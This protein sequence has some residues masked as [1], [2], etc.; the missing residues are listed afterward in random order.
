M[1]G[2]VDT[3]LLTHELP[4]F[5]WCP[6]CPQGEERRRRFYQAALR[7]LMKRLR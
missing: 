1:P 3:C 6:Y 4:G 2:V 5:D 7:A